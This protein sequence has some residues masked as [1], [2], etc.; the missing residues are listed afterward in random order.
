MLLLGSIMHFVFPKSQVLTNL[1]NQYAKNELYTEA[2]NTYTVITKNKS[3]N[4][5]GR[6]KVNMG[7]IHYKM[8]QYPKALKF[9]RM[10]L[11][12]VPSGQGSTK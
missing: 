1:A 11:D 7:N 10:A 4:N 6:L 12:Q 2:L 3:F 5:P 9:Y 8:E